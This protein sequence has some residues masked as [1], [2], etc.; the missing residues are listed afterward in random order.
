MQATVEDASIRDLDR[1]YEIETE[2]FRREAFTRTQ[3][4]QLLSG[5][6]SI[7][8]IARVEGQIIGFVIGEIYV[9][10]R[11]LQ[12]HICTIEI[13]PNFRRRGIGE[14]L[15]QEIEELFKQKGVKASALEVREDNVPAIE[16][17]RKLGYEKI[18][19]L[20]NYYGE[21]HGLYLGKTLT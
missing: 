15:L 1:L 4:A 6:N 10:R 2:C 12:G 17:Y 13:L 3:I 14:K 19:R 9:D 5:Y 16:L 7:A 18:G 8:L 11:V 21:T 20:R